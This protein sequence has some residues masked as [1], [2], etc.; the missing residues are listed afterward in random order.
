MEYLEQGLGLITA[1]FILLAGTHV[2]LGSV[3]A[4]LCAIARLKAQKENQ[5][6]KLATVGLILS[7]IGTIIALASLI[8]LICAAVILTGSGSSSY[9]YWW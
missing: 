3:A 2:F 1:G 9:D 6:T 7:I 4:V 8:C 5:S